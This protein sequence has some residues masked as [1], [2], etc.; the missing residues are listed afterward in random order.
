LGNFSWS[1]GDFFT[2]T[3]GHPGCFPEKNCCLLAAVLFG[4]SAIPQIKFSAKLK[5][6]FSANK[7]SANRFFGNLTWSRG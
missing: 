7:N 6:Y 3:Y 4:K 2:K 5:Q 1:L